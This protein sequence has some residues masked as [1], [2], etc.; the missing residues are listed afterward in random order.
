MTVHLFGAKSSSSCASYALTK[1][2]EDNEDNYSAEA[3]NSVKTNF[4]ADYCLRSMFSEEE[5]ISLCKELQDVC[6][7]GGFR[8]TKWISNCRAVLMSVPETEKT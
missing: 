4:Y 6:A 2:A 3:V 1:A 7:Q 5:A 8:L